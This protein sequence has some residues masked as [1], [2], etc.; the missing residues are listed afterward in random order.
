MGPEMEIPHLP[1]LNKNTGKLLY[2]G[3][4]W[5]NRYKVGFGVFYAPLAKQIRQRSSA[6]SSEHR[7]GAIPHIAYKPQI[8]GANPGRGVKYKY[9]TI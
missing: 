6:I 3:S 7:W 1:C 2:L 8:P 9:L 5:F 4:L